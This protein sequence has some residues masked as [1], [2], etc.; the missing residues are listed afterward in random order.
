MFIDKVTYKDY[1]GNEVTEE[2]HFNLTTAECYEFD[3]LTEG[4]L[5][6]YLERIQEE[7]DRK[8]LLKVFKTILSRSFGV[9]RGKGFYKSD[10]IREDFEASP[11]YSEM[12]MK[13]ATDGDY[14]SAFI[15]GVFPREMQEAAAA[16]NA[17]NSEEL[18]ISEIH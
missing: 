11:A 3:F 13:L 17:E 5:E 4:G 9:R 10:T 14:T 16:E 1:D 7:R 12:F 15:T 8:E 18:E 6:P 2:L